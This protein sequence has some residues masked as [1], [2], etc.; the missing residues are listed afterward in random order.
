MGKRYLYRQILA[1]G[2][3]HLGT[4]T[5]MATDLLVKVATE[6]QYDASH[7]HDFL[8]VYRLIIWLS[9]TV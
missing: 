4:C 2:G 7:L 9:P 1:P 6:L 8:I 5:T 3:Q